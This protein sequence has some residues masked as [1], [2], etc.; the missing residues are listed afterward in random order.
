MRRS[1]RYRSQ[2]SKKRHRSSHWEP[3]PTRTPGGGRNSDAQHGKEVTPEAVSKSIDL[4]TF[5]PKR[6]RLSSAPRSC[7]S[8]KLAS[9][10]EGA[11]GVRLVRKTQV[12]CDSRSKDHAASDVPEGSHV[13]A[14]RQNNERTENDVIFSEWDFRRGTDRWRSRVGQ[15]RNESIEAVPRESPQVLSPDQTRIGGGNGLIDSC[16][17]RERPTDVSACFESEPSEHLRQPPRRGWL[18]DLPA[19]GPLPQNSVY[20]GKVIWCFFSTARMG[21][22]VQARP[23]KR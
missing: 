20:I 1:R 17:T 6:K 11:T 21:E 22:P 5:R 10:H 23:T 13:E 2:S 14:Q 4:P 3:D 18:R 8:G 7:S 16:G 19:K 15:R 9:K 12:V